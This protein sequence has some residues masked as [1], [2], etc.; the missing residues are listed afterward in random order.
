MEI[1]DLTGFQARRSAGRKDV[2][3]IR[4]EEICPFPYDALEAELAKYG[5][6]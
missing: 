5:E 3:L 2:A 4:V 6:V 1:C